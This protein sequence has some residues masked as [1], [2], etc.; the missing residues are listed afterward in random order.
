MDILNDEEAQFLRTLNRG[1]ILFER[2]VTG[3]Q[4]T[5]LFPGDVA[6]RLYDTYGFPIDLTQL[7]A[8]EKGLTVDMEQYEAS[9]K[10]AVELSS[11]G[12]GKFHDT[13]DLNVHAIAELQQRG[14]PTTNDSP[15]YKYR[16]DG[17]LGLESQ[18]G[19]YH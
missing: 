3:L 2:A 16:D 11:A 15:K 18:Y 1:R 7:M 10:K 13:L 5:K 19:G 14:I 8:E 17:K 6:W 4:S 9:K 12:A